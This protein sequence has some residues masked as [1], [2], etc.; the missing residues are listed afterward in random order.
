MT[1]EIGNAHGRIALYLNEREAID[2]AVLYGSGDRAYDELMEAVK[3][4]YPKPDAPQE[5]K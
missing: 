1:F 2:L 3:Q 4:A 5:E